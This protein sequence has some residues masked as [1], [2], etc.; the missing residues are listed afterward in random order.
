[1][2]L[3]I[4]KED[5]YFILPESR[6]AVSTRIDKYMEEDFTLYVKSKSINESL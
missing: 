1:M 2:S 6:Y 3:R 5:V 4:G